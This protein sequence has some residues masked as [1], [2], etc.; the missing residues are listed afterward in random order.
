MDPGLEPDVCRLP[1]RTLA[2]RNALA[3][4]WQYL[5]QRVLADLLRRQP[6]RFRG[7]QAA[8]LDDLRQVG[9]VAL[10]KA[11]EAWDPARGVKFQTF[12]YHCIRVRIL[13][14]G[15]RRP[16]HRFVERLAEADEPGQAWAD[17]FQHADLYAALDRLDRGDRELLEQRFGL[18]GMSG[19]RTL[20]DLG[21]ERGL[22]AEAIRR[23]IAAALGE[24]C[25]H[26]SARQEPPGGGRSCRRRLASAHRHNDRRLPKRAVRV[27]GNPERADRHHASPGESAWSPPGEVGDGIGLRRWVSLASSLC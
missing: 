25:L 26:L 1:L 21:R 24:V 20:R 27:A 16:R 14:A 19:G 6:G 9:C 23:R 22:S 5:P 13:D 12:A 15:K 17:P 10:L 4:C 18:A 3:E 8:D 7:L 11:S 2:E